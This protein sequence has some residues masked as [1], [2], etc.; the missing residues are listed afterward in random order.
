M[1]SKT[2]VALAF[3]LATL[4][5]AQT[6]APKP[7]AAQPTGPIVSVL[8]PGGDNPP[9]DHKMPLVGSVIGAESA[10]TT[11]VASCAPGTEEDVCGMPTEGITMTQGPHTAMMS[12][13]YPA[14]SDD[15]TEYEGIS[16]TY[17]WDCKIAGTT[18]AECVYELEA[19]TTEGV[20]PSLLSKFKGGMTQSK[21]TT[22][23]EGSAVS[24]AMFGV[25]VTAGAEKL[26]QTGSAESTGQHASSAGSA[27]STGAQSGSSAGSAASP[28]ATPGLAAS[29]KVGGVAIGGALAAVFML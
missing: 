26:A 16:V 28:S 17:G 20:E 1:Y 22:T 18:S 12:A 3:A 9:G 29:V 13:G 27:E 19:S 23:L 25:T 10:L 4:S 15:D 14:W 6:T 11:L 8:L 21:S 24:N 7:T 2:T 5:S